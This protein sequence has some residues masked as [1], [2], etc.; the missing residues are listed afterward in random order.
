MFFPPWAVNENVMLQYMGLLESPFMKMY[1]TF[2]KCWHILQGP[3]F[4]CVC[5]HTNS[6]T[7]CCR[8]ALQCWCQCS[9]LFKTKASE[10][11]ASAF[12]NFSLNYFSY[13]R[14]SFTKHFFKNCFYTRNFC[15]FV[16]NCKHW[17]LFLKTF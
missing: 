14:S 12:Q 5:W 13:F 2:W 4:L 17:K 1:L 7:V 3:S 8:K 6:C 9:S 16:F 10:C 15:V 11:W